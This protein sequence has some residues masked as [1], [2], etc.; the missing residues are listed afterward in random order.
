MSRESER[1]TAIVLEAILEN[2]WSKVAIRNIEKIVPLM[3]RK[4]NVYTFQSLAEQTTELLQATD[5]IKNVDNLDSLR[6]DNFLQGFIHVETIC[7][8]SQKS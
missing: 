2:L 5:G 1:Q 7:K 6:R 3:L 8:K 4:M